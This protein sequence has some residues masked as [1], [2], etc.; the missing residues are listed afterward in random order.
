MKPQIVDT[1]VSKDILNNIQYWGIVGIDDIQ[2]GARIT[3]LKLKRILWDCELFIFL[4]SENTE[5]LTTFKG[6]KGFIFKTKE[7]A[8]RQFNEFL[9]YGS[10]YGARMAGLSESREGFICYED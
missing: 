2:T 10:K 9:K 5:V 8:V 7:E 6:C 1:D 3:H 4:T